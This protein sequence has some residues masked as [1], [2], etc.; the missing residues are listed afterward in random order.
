MKYS[1]FSE[2]P[3]LFQTSSA[4]KKV[5][6]KF[7]KTASKEETKPGGKIKKVIEVLGDFTTPPQELSRNCPNPN[8]F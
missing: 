8:F 4:L 1:N 2:Q 6:A 3:E 7:V 5:E